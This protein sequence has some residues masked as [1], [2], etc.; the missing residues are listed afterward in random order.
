M[1]D[2]RAE[3]LL[4]LKDNTI[5]QKEDSIHMRLINILTLYFHKLLQQFLTLSTFFVGFIL[6]HPFT[7]RPEPAYKKNISLKWSD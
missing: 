3:S 4:L 6:F 7:L 2:S 5:T 1:I